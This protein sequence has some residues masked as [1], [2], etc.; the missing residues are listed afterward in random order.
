MP[1]RRSSRPSQGP[2]QKLALLPAWVGLALAGSA[3]AVLYAGLGPLASADAGKAGAQ[4]AAAASTPAVLAF[5]AALLVGGVAILWAALQRD[6]Q[7]SRPP[8]R[9]RPGTAAEAIEGMTAREF[10]ALLGEAFKLQ[11]YQVVK[12]DGSGAAGVDLLLRKDR[13]TVLVHTQRWRSER[14]GAETLVALQKAMSARSATGGFVV[15]AGRFSREAHA[16]AAQANL[17]LIDGPVLLGLVVK[18][19]ALQVSV[20]Q[21]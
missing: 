14:V 8:R 2:L 12:S 6:R 9:G 7:A 15:T 5:A 19:R 1:R 16:F 11:G 13:E 18:A 17:R 20:G 4:A 3:A 10:E 21:S